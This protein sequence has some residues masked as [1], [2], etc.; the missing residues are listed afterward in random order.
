[1]NCILTVDGIKE[2]LEI[3]KQYIVYVYPG[4]ITLVIYR[5]AMSKSIEENKNTFIKS[6]IISYLYTLPF[7]L[8]G[9][10]PIEFGFLPHFIIII[11]A[12]ILPFGWNIVICRDKFKRIIRFL[13]IKTEIY[14][15]LMDIMFYKEGGCVWVRA[16]MD[17][18]KIMYEGS[19]RHYES[20]INREQQIILSGYRFYNYNKTTKKYDLLVYDY[21]S[22]QKQWVRLL[23]KNITRMEFVYQ[24]TH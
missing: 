20:D 23:E 17:N 3:I 2:L 4:F 13:G 11:F 24:Q 1:M 14:D 22:D 19:L 16:Y 5:F 12:I 10:N 6:I 8:G 7:Q 15:N 18:Q 9:K 21:S